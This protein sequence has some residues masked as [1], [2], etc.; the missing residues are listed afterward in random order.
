VPNK[1]PSAKVDF[2]ILK[3]KIVP[4]KPFERHGQS[5]WAS[6]SSIQVL[7]VINILIEIVLAL[8]VLACK[9]NF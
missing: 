7:P 4:L 8:H 3:Q 6:D 1:Y 9:S 5:L 2:R